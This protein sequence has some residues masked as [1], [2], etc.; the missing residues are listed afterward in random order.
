MGRGW[1]YWAAAVGAVAT[2]CLLFGAEPSSRAQLVSECERTLVKPGLALASRLSE[3]LADADAVPAD[4]WDGF[5]K[6]A[7]QISERAWAL[8]DRARQQWC[9]TGGAADFA[10]YLSTTEALLAADHLT[11]VPRLL[12]VSYLDAAQARFA[13]S[14]E[15][16]RLA[17]AGEPAPAL[18]SIS[19]ARQQSPATQTSSGDTVYITS[20]GQ[21]FH[22]AGCRFLKKSSTPIARSEA[23]ARGYTPCSV[24]KP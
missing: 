6:E 12:D 22:R 16:A 9:A 7:D 17:A 23:L 2:T 21:K 1:L 15:A 4:V 10:A 3:A 18:E 20:T 5:A 13:A 14:R 8:T 24:C 19:A 11:M